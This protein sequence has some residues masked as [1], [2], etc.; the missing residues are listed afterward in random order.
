M[1]SKRHINKLLERH[2]R[3][4]AQQYGIAKR[5][6]IVAGVGKQRNH[7]LS[8]STS[9]LLSIIRGGRTIEKCAYLPTHLLPNIKRG[10]SGDEFNNVLYLLLAHGCFAETSLYRLFALNEA[11][12]PQQNGQVGSEFKAP[13]QFYSS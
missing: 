6:A 3:K 12:P 11:I 1:W 10:V 13:P 7:T 2:A 4:V 5:E 8:L 9:C